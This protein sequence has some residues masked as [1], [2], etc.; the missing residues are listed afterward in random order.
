M[1]CS[2]LL[3]SDQKYLNYQF[4]KY[5]LGQYHIVCAAFAST[6][7]FGNIPVVKSATPFK[8]YSSVLGAAFGLYY[9]FSQLNKSHF[10]QVYTPYFE[11]YKVK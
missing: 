7:V 11:K 10:E 8:Y 3:E 6:F 5:K 2:R 1:N 4:E 9:V